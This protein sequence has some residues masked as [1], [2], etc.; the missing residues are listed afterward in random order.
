MMK[1]P[2]QLSYVLRLRALYISLHSCD[3]LL[4]LPPILLV[5]TSDKLYIN[6]L[7][8]W[9]YDAELFLVYFFNQTG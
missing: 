9:V 6:I 4:I 8:V 7:V 1:L 5:P 2:T 3:A